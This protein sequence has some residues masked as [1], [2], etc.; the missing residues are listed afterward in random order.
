MGE[1]GWGD[2]LR[3]GQVVVVMVIM[4]LAM[5]IMVRWRSG[6]DHDCVVILTIFFSSPAVR[7]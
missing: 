1:G 5:V 2:V 3:G 4:V 7:G 6:D